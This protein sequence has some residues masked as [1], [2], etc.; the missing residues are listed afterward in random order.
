V[1]AEVNRVNRRII[2]IFTAANIPQATS[3]FKMIIIILDIYFI[4]YC[5]YILK[6][7]IDDITVFYLYLQSWRAFG[8]HVLPLIRLILV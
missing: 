1:L 7:G 6:R 5:L 8:Y 2:V 4:T 3:V